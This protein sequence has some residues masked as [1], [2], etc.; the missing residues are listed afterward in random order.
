MHKTLE[1]SSIPPEKQESLYEGLMEEA[2]RGWED[3]EF[4]DKNEA[5]RQANR[6]VLAAMHGYE[7][8]SLLRDIFEATKMEE[9]GFS[10][11]KKKISILGEDFW[12]DHINFGCFVQGKDGKGGEWVDLDLEQNEHCA[13]G[14]GVSKNIPEDEKS[15]YE[16]MKK[17]K[18]NMEDVHG[19]D[20]TFLFSYGSY[21]ERIVV[22]SDT[23]FSL[24]PDYKTLFSII[25][26]HLLKE[27]MEED[28]HQDGRKT[29]PKRA[30]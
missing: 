30:L 16:K 17:L 13:V 26:S 6:E 27:K 29:Q 28:F 3:I 15:F 21:D 25:D 12:V 8:K 10:L 18:E 20:G 23:L 19:L 9:L 4:L 11:E 2:L 14:S 5:A 22:K 7:V 1:L 24:F